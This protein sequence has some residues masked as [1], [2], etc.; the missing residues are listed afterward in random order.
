[1]DTGEGGNVTTAARCYTAGFGGGRE[2]QKC[3]EHSFGSWKR[4][5]NCFPLEPLEEVQPCQHI[6]FSPVKLILNF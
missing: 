5:G 4:Q 1:M 3:N 6:D 2:G